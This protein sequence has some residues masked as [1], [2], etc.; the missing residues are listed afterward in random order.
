MSCNCIWCTVKTLCHVKVHDV[1]RVWSCVPISIFIEAIHC[2][3]TYM[4]MM[5][6]WSAYSSH[7]CICVYSTYMCIY[8]APLS[9]SPP[10][11][12]PPSSPSPLLLSTS[13]PTSLSPFPLPP[14]LSPSP[15]L[16]SPSSPPSHYPDG[17]ILFCM[18][19]MSL[20]STNR[21][22]EE[23]TLKVSPFPT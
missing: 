17:Q 8:V 7:V 4:T 21:R 3:C 11:L 5:C 13:S 15:L 20:L 6:T 19:L 12:L 10:P 16:L 22:E 23:E 2:T 14:S 9:S 1:I 18:Y